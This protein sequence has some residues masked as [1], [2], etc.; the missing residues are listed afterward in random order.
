MCRVL[1]LDDDPFSAETVKLILENAGEANADTVFTEEDAVA[2]TNARMQAG[3]PYEV[4]LIDQRLGTGK[5]GIDVFKD[6]RAIC[7]DADGI[8]F[9]GYED[10]E[11]GLRAYEAGAFRYLSKPFENRELLFLLKAVKQWRK[12]QREHGWQKL[13]SGMMEAALQERDFD[14]VSKVVVNY[15][16]KLG[17]ERAHLFWV[18]TR[19]DVNDEGLLVGITSS[20]KGCI[21]NFESHLFPLRDWYDLNRSA[22]IRNAIFRR[23]PKTEEA[24]KQLEACGYELPASEAAILPLWR[25]AALAGALVLD[26]AQKSRVLTEHERSLLNLFA[27]QVSIALDHA[28]V[29]SHEQWMLQQSSIIRNIGRRI[30]AKA[31]SMNLVQLLEEVRQQIGQLMDVSNFAVILCDQETGERDFHLLY[32]NNVRQKAMRRVPARGLEEYLLSQASEVFIPRAVK[33]FA[34]EKKLVLKG[35]VPSGFLGVLLRVGVKNIGGIMVRKFGN[36]SPFTLREKELLIMAAD[37]I[38]GAIQIR[39]LSESE[40]EDSKRLQILQRAGMELLRV[41][42]KYEE[43]FWYTVL[44]IATADF[45]LGFNSALLFLMDE[46][47]ENWICERAIGTGDTKKARSDWRRDKKREFTFNQFLQNLEDRKTRFTDYEMLRNKIKVKLSDVDGAL[48]NLLN[49][50]DRQII[51]DL[52]VLSLLPAEIT[53]TVSLSNCAVLPLRLGNELQGFV[54]VDNKHNHKPLTEKSLDGLQ[55]LLNNAGQVYETLRQQEKSKELL[56][57]NYEILNQASPKPS[58]LKETLDRIC[59]TARK[60][61][62]ADWVLVYPLSDGQDHKFDTANT[63]YAGQLKYPIETAIKEKPSQYGISSHVLEK[64]EFVIRDVDHKFARIGRRKISSSQF[65]RQEGVKAVIGIAIRDVQTGKA[66]GILYLDYRT[67][68]DFAEIE[69]H[70]A[71]SFASLAAYAIASTRKFDEK[72]LRLRM[73]AALQTVDAIGTELNLEKMLKKVLDKLHRFFENTTLCVL[74][75]DDDEH[76]LRFAPSTLEFYEIENPDYIDQA[77]FPLDGDSIA[78][79]AARRSLLTKQPEKENVSNVNSDPNYLPLILGTTSELCVSML[80]SEKKLLGVLV[81]ERSD[82][83][84]DDDDVELVEMVARQL[85][86]GMERAIQNENLEFQST[87]AAAYVWAADLAHDINREVGNIRNWAYLIRE[88]S[89]SAKHLAE[90]AQKIEESAADLSGAGPWT[91]PLIQVIGFDD[92]IERSIRAVTRQKDVNVQIVPGCPGLR[93]SM[94]PVAFQRII[95]QLV[96]NADQAMAKMADKKIVIRTRPVNEN[97]EVEIVFQDFG[98]GIPAS[99]SSSILNR[100]TTTKG[101]GGYGLLFARQMVESMGGKIKLLPSELGKGAAFSIKFPVVSGGVTK[102]LYEG[103]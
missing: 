3:K 53:E 68:Q 48:R 19:E 78:C 31:A 27:R 80:N 52:H 74:T 40:V 7:P 13:F 91:N 71:K 41:A 55:A 22:K 65:I 17:F 46:N 30:T 4:F 56:N 50:G 38:A 54:I 98:P 45:G 85:G 39:W 97:M 82:R 14:A 96:R 103:E 23:D 76:A 75:Y 83:T 37:Q 5:D 86:L 77:S 42:Q 9:T 99:V 34:K 90:Y 28:S 69:I 79:R 84:F 88:K 24:R 70:H 33:E 32:E 59:A 49:S 36:E 63:S 12:E 29:F 11:N 60:I 47:K 21:T 92:A 73:E 81:L 35:K 26:Y 20:G 61:M 1:I 102:S 100:R 43:Y 10:V 87:V 101:R 93:V 51:L 62:E 94:N 6:L 57:A 89:G 64:G 66:L 44:T 67:P 8:I 16:L 58:R 15:S 18:P 95:R 72:R 2:R 25:G